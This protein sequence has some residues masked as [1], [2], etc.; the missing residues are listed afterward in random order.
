MDISRRKVVQYDNFV[1]NTDV[2]N[3]H[4]THTSGS[5]AGCKDDG[6]GLDKG[7]AYGAKIAFIDIGDSG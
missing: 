5:A 3:G 2:E 6:L 4:G 7:I 1:D